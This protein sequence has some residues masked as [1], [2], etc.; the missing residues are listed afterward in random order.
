M[1]DAIA[2]LDYYANLAEDL[3]NQ[4]GYPLD[5]SDQDFSS[6]VVREPMGVIAAITPWNYPLLMALQKVAPALAAGCC[7]VLK[8]SE[9][10]P[11]SCLYLADAAKE[12][13]APPG[14][15]NVITG[16]ASTGSFLSEHRCVD[17]LSFTGSR[18]TGCKVMVAAAL[19][20]PKPASLELGGKSAMIVFPDAD[21][22]STI[23]WIMV[24][25]FINCGQVCSSTS[26]LLLHEDIS[27]DILQRL[28]LKTREVKLA[29]PGMQGGKVGP[30]VSAAQLKK[31][32]GFVDRAVAAGAQV[33]C[34]GASP[35]GLDGQSGYFFEPTI[36]TNIAEDSEIWQE[37]VF[38]PVLSVRTFKTQQDA[39]AAANRSRY[40]LAASV[41]SSSPETCNAVARALRVGIVWKN[42]SQPALIEAPWGGYKQSGVGRENGVWGLEEFLEIKQITGPKQLGHSWEWFK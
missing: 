23:D 36:L 8:P 9:L 40:G 10:A 34:G 32:Q 17:A 41:M 38:G 1:S 15:L 20:G 2:T 4:K 24:G 21:I 14:A 27:D 6:E 16:S 30:I 33:L 12:A 42:C 22:E 31:V 35:K 29:L 37:E 3:A 25:G 13:G 39:V 28:L 11:L 19:S 26:R 5:V 7:V 18:A